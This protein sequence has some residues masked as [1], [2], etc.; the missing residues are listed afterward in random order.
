MASV[1]TWTGGQ[2][3]RSLLQLAVRYYSAGVTFA[4]EHLHARRIIYR[5]GGGGVGIAGSWFFRAPDLCLVCNLI[6][7]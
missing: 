4:F 3:N 7:L 1:A 5:E 6:V 2:S